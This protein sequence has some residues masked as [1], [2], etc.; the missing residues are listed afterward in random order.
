M[1]NMEVN[2]IY[3]DIEDV[4]LEPLDYPAVIEA[5][6][7][8]SRLDERA[9]RSPL[10]PGWQE[11][12]LFDEAVACQIAEGNLVHLD[13]LVLLDS[14]GRRE[15]THPDLRDTLAMLRTWR[16][17]VSGDASD[18]LQAEQPGMG[19]MALA[20]PSDMLRKPIKFR[21]ISAGPPIDERPPT[22]LEA[23]N[24][25]RR[26]VRGSAAMTP[27]IAAAVAWDSWVTSVPEPGSGWRASLLAA[28][29]LR[30]RGVTVSY[31]LPIDTGRKLTSYRQRPDQPLN[32]R[33]MG[34]IGWM[35][36]AAVRADKQLDAL[37]LAEKLLH[38]KIAARRRPSRLTALI[39]LFLSRPLVSIPLAARHLNC[40]TQAVEKM[41]PLLGSTPVLVT[42]R[43]RFRAWRVA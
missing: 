30:Q 13:D 16:A 5:H 25:W 10:A 42:E 36:A 33:L 26:I 41:L 31:V 29:V 4:K 35:H 6:G 34:F 21:G 32:E 38:G 43:R 14:D 24:R 11:R 3:Y 22:D 2:S 27:L 8:I 18:L 9:K 20:Q 12:L 28:L 37:V 15:K 1:Q 40:S 19:D 7:A 23:L 17:A 39:D